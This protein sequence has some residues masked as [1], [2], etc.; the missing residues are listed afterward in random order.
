MRPRR[1]RL[2][3]PSMRATTSSGSSTYSSVRPRTNSPGW[4]TNESLVADLHELGE[5]LRRVGQVD[6]R[7]AVVVEDA[8]RAAQAQ[9]DAGRLD[10][11]LVPRLDAH[12]AL[13]HQA[14]DRPVGEDGGRGH[15]A[16]VCQRAGSGR[17]T[18]GRRAWRGRPPSACAAGRAGPDRRAGR[19]AGGAGTAGAGGA[20]AWCRRRRPSAPARGRARRGW[21]TRRSTAAPTIGILSA[22][23]SQ[24]KPHVTCGHC[25]PAVRTVHARVSVPAGRASGGAAASAIATRERRARTCRRSRPALRALG[26]HPRALAAGAQHAA[27]RAGDVEAPRG[28]RQRG[29]PC[30]AQQG[31]AHAR[32]SRGPGARWPAGPPRRTPAPR[33]SRSPSAARSRRRGRWRGS[34]R[35]APRGPRWC[36][37]SSPT[38][39]GARAGRTR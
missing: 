39:R 11:G 31:G 14:A 15:P 9:V 35:R 21:P 23:M 22:N 12:A 26:A 6:G 7:D 2:D 33:P 29:R 18:R 13:G 5:V 10:H 27:Q 1:P 38:A 25:T 24:R 30:R 32:S 16:E 28:D 37:R 36:A 4:M 17:P 19:G 3:L 20:D 8:E 34:P